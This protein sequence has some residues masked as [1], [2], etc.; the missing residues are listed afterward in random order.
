MTTSFDIFLHGVGAAVLLVCA[1]LC[2]IFA[3]SGDYLALT[4]RVRLL[5]S[6]CCTTCVLG[7]IAL[8]WRAYVGLQKL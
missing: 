8:A 5:Y 3:T 6:A 4:K 2:L 1:F 7:A